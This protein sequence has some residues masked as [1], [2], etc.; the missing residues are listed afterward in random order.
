M[1]GRILVTGATGLIGREVVSALR[2]EPWTIVPT[3]R[4]DADLPGHCRCDLSDPDSTTALLETVQPIAIVH[5]AGGTSA[6][7]HELY[8]RNVLSTI[9]LLEAAARLAARPY[10]V[11]FGSA[12]EYGEGAGELVPETAAL[13]PVSEY[14]HAKVA[15]IRLA[16]WIARERGL[17][18]TVLRPFNVVSCRLP[19]S[20]PLGNLRQQLLST[21][22][23]ER[24][25]ECGRL[26]VV[27]DFV[28]LSAVAE[29][30]RRLLANPAPGRVFNVCSG[31]GIELGSVL[32]A[33]AAKL[34][35]RLRIVQEP[36]LVAV[37]SARRVVGDPRAL[38]DAVG[39][40]IPVTPDL[41]AG[42]VLGQEPARPSAY[43]SSMG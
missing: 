41:L 36:E 39:L 31:V 14:G 21:A 5:L 20:T 33:M 38:R 11:V 6:D 26:D 19:P 25:V 8:R 2:Q 30:V 18:L 28:P 35:V 16:E 24:V 3:S 13:R 10:C 15:Q 12:A 37:P 9:H 23:P 29:A 27:R 7:L 40:G 17:R 32:E 43:P 4:S 1:S 42:L 34:G 22:G